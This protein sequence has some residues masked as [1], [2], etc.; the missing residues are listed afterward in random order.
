MTPRVTQTD[1]A[2]M[3]G[4]SRQ[5]VSLVI[6]DDPRVSPE[7]KQAVLRAIETTGYRPNRA[8]RSLAT[9]RSGVIGIIV[10]DFNNPFYGELIQQI[11]KASE[12][13]NLTPFVTAAEGS[14]VPG[15][16]ERF[17]DF[18]VDGLV[19]VAPALSAQQI[20][21][22]AETVPT[23]L[24]TSSQ[25]TEVADIIRTDDYE[26]ARACTQILLDQAYSPVL[27]VGRRRAKDTT[28]VK[29][30]ID[31][32]KSA[33]HGIQVPKVVLLEDETLDEDLQRLIAD[34]GDNRAGIVAHDDLLAF[35]TA[36]ICLNQGKILGKQIGITG[37]D[38]TYLS[39]FPGSQ[40]TTVDQ[41]V[42]RMGQLAV[43][44]IEQRIKGRTTSRTEVIPPRVIKRA[45][46]RSK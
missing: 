3:A 33:V 2:K 16:I 27:F 34:L 35:T 36:A 31:G 32:Y 17:I 12:A 14:E 38:N 28:S 43:S 4:V 29:A 23:A 10:A 45:S 15:A 20:D 25:E 26:G 41:N 13:K 6:N 39:R 37:F 7:S 19:L 11:R 1:V 8:A 9:A 5:T 46:T 22:Y 44:S 18:G 40:L 42:V 30:R 24:L 21:K